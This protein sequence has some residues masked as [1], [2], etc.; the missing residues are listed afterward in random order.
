MQSSFERLLY[1]FASQGPADL[2]KKNMDPGGDSPL[3]PLPF[4]PVPAKLEGLS[5]RD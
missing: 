5:S 4:L 3:P 1:R 2:A